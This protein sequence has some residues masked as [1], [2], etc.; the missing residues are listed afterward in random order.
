MNILLINPKF[1]D[2]FWSFSYALRFI[3]KKSAIPP[4]GLIMVAA[5]RSGQFQI[6]LVDLNVDTLGDD[7]LAWADIAFISA[8]A[9]QRLI[10]LIQQSGIATAMVGML[11]TP[12][13]TRLFKH[14]ASGHRISEKFSSDNVD[15]RST[16]MPVMG[17]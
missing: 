6:R 10:D 9:V 17:L 5:L 16:I 1:S 11:Q 4:L 14:L 12:A 8:M 13:G 7:D 2:T 3:G 15:G